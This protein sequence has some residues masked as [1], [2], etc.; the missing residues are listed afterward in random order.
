VFPLNGSD[1]GLLL[2][3]ADAAMYRSKETGRNDYHYFSE[4]LNAQAIRSQRL[5]QEIKNAVELE[6]FNIEFQPQVR[7]SDHQVV[8]V[9]AFLRWPHHDGIS[10]AELVGVLEATGLS[11]GVGHWLLRRVCAQVQAW[12]GSSALQLRAAVNVGERQLL[13]SGFARSVASVL[14][15]YGLDG[16]SLELEVQE[17]VL[18][19]NSSRVRS[20]LAELHE[21]GVRVVLDDFGV[22]CSSLGCLQRYG[23]D[24]LKVDRSLIAQIGRQESAQ[25]LVSALIATARSLKLNVVAEGVENEEQL[26]FLRKERCTAVQGYFVARPGSARSTTR[27]LAVMAQDGAWLSG[28]TSAELAVAG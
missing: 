17:K 9:E 3:R 1:V 12:N 4:E 23:V 5:Q 13:D 19:G 8:A 10:T 27:W 21:L 2:Q 20:T 18:L 25:Q 6:E 26:A 15:E 22:G 7:L 24:T 11:V 14:A 28:D 16:D